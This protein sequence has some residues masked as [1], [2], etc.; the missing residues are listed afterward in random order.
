MIRTGLALAVLAACLAAVSH[1]GIATDAG[2]AL[3]DALAREDPLAGPEGRRAIVAV[4]DGEPERRAEI[5]RAVARRAVADPL[6]AGVESG[7]GTDAAT[8]DWLWRHRL[9]LAPPAPEDLTAGAMAA[10]LA[11]ARE[12]LVRAEGMALG[13]RLLRDPT[14]SFARLLATLGAARPDLGATGGVWRSRDGRA[15]LVFLELADRPFAAA[16][17]ALLADALRGEAEA[18]GA[19]AIVVGPRVIA[20]EVTR[21]ME[22]GSALSAG[23]AGGLLL[24]WLAWALRRPGRIL[25][26]A[27]PLALGLTVATLTVAALHGTVHVIALGFGGALTGLAIDYPLHLGQHAPAARPQAARLVILGALTTA[28]AFLAL[29]GSGIEALAQTGVFVAT[30]LVTAALASLAL[31]PS[32]G[33]PE[34]RARPAEAPPRPAPRAAAEIALALAGLAV[35]ATEAGEPDPA[36]TELPAETEAALTELASLL[37]LPSGRQVIDIRGRDAEEVL[38]R[39]RA[40]QPVLEAAIAAGELGAGRSLGATLPTRAAQAR[41]LPDPARLEA[42]ARAALA[43]AGLRPSFAE[44]IGRAYAEGLAAEP[45]TPRALA[46]APGLSALASGFRIGPDGARDRV[47]L[48]EVS[49]PDALRARLA[50]AAIP[51]VRLVDRAAEIGAALEELRRAVLTWF[52]LG[53]AAAAGLLLLAVRPSGRA[54]GLLRRTAAALGLTLAVLW[55]LGGPPGIFE[56]VALTLVVGIGIDYGLFLAGGDGAARRSVGL[57]AAST[58]IAFGVMALSPVALLSEIGLTVSLGVLAMLGLHGTATGAR[59]SAS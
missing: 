19:R 24:L 30:G 53:A 28:L 49:A 27:L 11:E 13:D 29:L 59:E 9:R 57:C 43:A 45:V 14:G 12:A 3:G 33:A 41:P 4:L 52:G 23:A 15:A 6:V 51:G 48:R 7:P 22:R 38:A 31:V 21:Q 1:I 5:A 26:L 56:I 34:A 36:L 39:G 50:E 35:L 18:A 47:R 58:L 20:A 46:A 32:E 54:L 40:L 17:V 8:L 25:A 37:P 42:R 16:E 44:A 10:R 55:A 2:S